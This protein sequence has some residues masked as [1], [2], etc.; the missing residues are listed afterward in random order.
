MGKPAA[1]VTDMHTCPMV[2]GVVPHVGGPIIPPCQFNVL[3]CLM[4][5]ARISDMA[6]CV[7]PIDMII[8]G[9]PTVLVGGLPAARLGD[10][11]VHGGVI[12]TGCFTVLIGEAGGGGGGGGAETDEPDSDVSIGKQAKA[13]IAELKEGRY[14]VRK[15]GARP[16]FGPASPAPKA[17]GAAAGPKAGDKVKIDEKVLKNSPTLS[18]QIEELE[19]DGWTIKYGDAGKGSFC[20]KS[21]KSITIDPNMGSNQEDLTQTVAHEV[22]HAKYTGKPDASSKK[23]YVDSQ[24]ADEGAATMKY[25]KLQRENKKNGGSDIGIAGTQG[26]KYSKVYDEYEKDGDADKARSKMGQV[27]GDGEKTSNTNQTYN[28][29]YGDFYDKN[30]KPKPTK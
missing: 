22:G 15:G 11:T 25:I 3:T 29:Y 4:P 12:I 30:L 2:T 28:D 17:G 23:A 26:P 20:S 9:S 6:I 27:F 1:R 13:Y 8:Q 24:L 18:K 14:T 10:M 5:Q 16:I 7:G 19:K 21:T